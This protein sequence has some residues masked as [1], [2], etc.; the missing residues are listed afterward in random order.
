VDPAAKGKN[1]KQSCRDSAALVSI[2][3]QEATPQK[4]QVLEDV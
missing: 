3:M 4:E 2:E 1:E